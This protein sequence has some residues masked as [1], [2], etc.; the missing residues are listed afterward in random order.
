L[1]TVGT[2]V[3]GLGVFKI[4]EYKARKDGLIDRKEEY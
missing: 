2:M 4:A 3:L 1:T